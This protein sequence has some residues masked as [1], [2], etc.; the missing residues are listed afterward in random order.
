MIPPLGFHVGFQ[1]RSEWSKIIQ[2]G[3]STIDLE[4][5]NVEELSLQQILTLLAPVLLA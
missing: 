1:S 3:D 4:G 5:L 2:T